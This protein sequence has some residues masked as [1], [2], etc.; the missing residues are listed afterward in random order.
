MAI[1]TANTTE[2]CSLIESMRMLNRCQVESLEK[3][4]RE[5]DPSDQDSCAK[6]N[7]YVTSVQATIIYNFKLTSFRAMD[8]EDP[9]EAAALWLEMKTL[10]EK[11]MKVLQTYKD[12]YPYCGTPELYDFTL[13]CWSEAVLVQ[14]EMD[15][16]SSRLS[17]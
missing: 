4:G 13:A 11:A 14:R 2:D 10:C 7:K 17:H 3:A 16:S 1:M 6:F 12:L 8:M 9:G 15:F 5:L